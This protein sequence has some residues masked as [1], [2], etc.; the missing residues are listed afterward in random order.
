MIVFVG[1]PQLNCVRVTG[2]VN[3]SINRVSAF[4]FIQHPEIVFKPLKSA[5]V[6]RSTYVPQVI[7][8]NNSVSS[9]PNQAIPTY[10]L[11]LIGEPSLLFGDYTA[12]NTLQQE[13]A[14]QINQFLNDQSRSN[15]MIQDKGYELNILGVL[16]II[17]TGLFLNLVAKG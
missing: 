13:R 10:G 15:L 8:A 6:D 17:L 16:L 4:G 12:N 9:D 5:Q 2:Q 7:D 14:D 11:K 3:C 1:P